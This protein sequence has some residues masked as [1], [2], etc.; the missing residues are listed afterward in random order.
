[1]G[2]TIKADNWGWRYAGRRE[3]A[4][5]NLSFSI[6]PGQRVLLLGASGGGKSTLLAGLAG[7]LGDGDEG[8]EAGSLTIGHRHPRDLKGHAALMMQDPESQIVLARIGDD[9]AF[10]CENMCV[11]SDKIWPRVT[12]A[13]TSVG[14]HLGLDHPSH[15][16]SG[17][18]QQRLVLA[19]ALAMGAEILLLDEPTANLDVEGVEEVRQGVSEAVAERERTLIVVEHRSEVWVPLVDRVMV[20]GPQGVIADGEPGEVFSQQ[21]DMLAD[22]GVWVPESYVPRIGKTM[23]FRVSTTATR[24][25]H[26]RH[27]AR[28]PQDPTPSPC[29]LRVALA[30]SAAQAPRLAESIPTPQAKPH[31]KDDHPTRIDPDHQ[32]GSSLLTGVDLSVGYDTPAQENLFIDIPQGL[33]T[34][35]TGVNGSGKTALALTLAGLLPPLAGSVEAAP[36]LAP[37]GKPH[38]HTWKSAELLTRI[39]TVF[40]SPDHQFTAKTVFDEIAVGLRALRGSK[41]KELVN[42]TANTLLDQFRLS[43]LAQ[44]NPFTLS[45]GEK[46]RLCV[47]T[48]L[49]CNPSVIIL[50]EPTFGQD[51]LTWMAMVEIVWQ[52]KSGGTTIISVT[53]D[54]EYIEALGDH[55]IHLEL[56]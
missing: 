21:G 45:G 31:T 40:Q 5:H 30:G 12:S 49:A 29:A 32:V 2:S 16:L 8:E 17:G 24:S 33:S 37:A 7:V 36:M 46:R 1:M 18:Q 44:A 19:G 55:R 22:Q 6:E 26:S 47:A 28:Q 43:H 15:H 38:P 35:I 14:L 34:V 54:P 48:V 53:H 10:G 11:E 20:V 51:R 4:I 39:Q 41:N 27:S 56:P 9:V 25:S 23:D 13:L 3:W 42:E 50:D 52:L